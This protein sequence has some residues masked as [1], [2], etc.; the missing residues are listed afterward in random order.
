MLIFLEDELVLRKEIAGWLREAGFEVDEA[1]TLAQF[2]QRFDPARH[3]L[4]LLD[5]GLPDGDGLALI[6]DLRARGEKVGI[7]VLTAR[8][9]GRSKIEGLLLGADHFF[10]KPVDL[11]ELAA[12]LHALARRLET[13][14][15]NRHWILDTLQCQLL[16]PG[17]A[18]I[19]LVGQAYIVLRAIVGGK[20]QPVSRRQ[21]VEAL[22]QSYLQYDL[23][24]LDTQIHDIRKT[25]RDA[26]GLELPIR[27]VRGVGYQTAARF[28]L[29]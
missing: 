9:T 11:E 24:R 1:G 4:A 3:T 27:T 16:P 2:R 8:N 13:G 15:P 14:G 18:P 17:K 28:D 20:G 22:G 10:H 25:V 26:C 23:R 19:R 5:L 21:I 7:V 6:E 12:A 29:R